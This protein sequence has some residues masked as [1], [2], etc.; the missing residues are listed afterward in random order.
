MYDTCRHGCRY[1][2]AT[3]SLKTVARNTQAHDPN[4]PLLCGQILA[5]DIVKDRVVHSCRE[6][7]VSF[8]DFNNGVKEG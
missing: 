8:F 2:Y 1:C 7:Q 6:E 3:H 4:S 5:E